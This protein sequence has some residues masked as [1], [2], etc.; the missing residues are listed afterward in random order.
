MGICQRE[1]LSDCIYLNT[2]SDARFKTNRISI[3][4]VTELQ[5][6]T[7]AAYALLPN[8]LRKGNQQHPDFTEFNQYLNELYGAYVDCGV[9][10]RGDA[11][12]VTL[13]IVSIDDKFTL[14]GE[15]LTAKLVET[16]CEML[17]C[18]A[19]ENNFFSEKEIALEKETLIDTIRAEI[20][21]KRTYALNRANRLMCAGEPAGLS[22]YG[23][24][25]QVQALTKEEVTAA[26]HQLLKTAR[27]ELFFTG[28]GDASIAKELFKNRLSTLVREANPG[29]LAMPHQPQEQLIEE[30]E[31][32][33][34]AQSKMV[35]GF[36]TGTMETP[37]QMAATQMM[38]AILG[39]TPLSKLF[40]NVREKLSLC[41]YCAARLD[42]VKGMLKIDS[43]VENQ[44][45]EKAKTEIMHQLEE[46]QNGNFTE[47]EISNALMSLENAYRTTN[48]SNGALE[49]YYLGQV[50]QQPV[51]SPEKKA[52]LLAKVTREEIIQAANG[53]TFELCYVLT[54]KEEK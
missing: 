7:A 52:A 17:L 35:L 47:E 37:E 41:Y 9:Q 11:Q 21:E 20:N 16:L 24:V 46:L 44:N 12:L 49:G 51:L 25:E 18:P 2:I 29:K 6:K 13:S 33:D 26:Y 38:V 48:D 34:V 43:G 23:T 1:E 28:S 31:R 53:V 27:I 22:K 45:I 10:K 14:H 54:G 42:A 36:S 19:F 5:E 50:L 15:E 30:M 8:L 3:F 40:V 32:I 39:G 4:L